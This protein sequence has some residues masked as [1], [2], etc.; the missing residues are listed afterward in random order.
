V[1]WLWLI[2]TT[3]V[4]LTSPTVGFNPTM[5]LIEAGQVIEPSV[6]VP[7]AAATMPAATAAPDPDEDPQ[8][9]RS[10]ACGLRVWPPMALQPEMDD[11]DRMFAHSDRFVLPG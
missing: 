10:S 3:C 1:S 9:L 7:M 2:G 11:D 6:S 5:P 8:A 4:R